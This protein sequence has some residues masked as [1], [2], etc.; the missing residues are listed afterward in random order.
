M[1]INKWNTGIIFKLLLHK[2]NFT[3]SEFTFYSPPPQYPFRVNPYLLGL[4]LSTKQYKNF[5]QK[6]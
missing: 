1:I 4:K 5:S 6:G 2:Y 3:T